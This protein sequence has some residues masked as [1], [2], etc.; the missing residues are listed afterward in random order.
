[1]DRSPEYHVSV[2]QALQRCRGQSHELHWSKRWIGLTG[3]WT[4]VETLLKILSKP[5]SYFHAC[6]DTYAGGTSTAAQGAAS[7]AMLVA[8]S[9]TVMLVAPSSTAVMLVAPSSAVVMLVAPSSTA[10][11][12]VAL[13]RHHLQRRRRM[14]AQGAAPMLVASLAAVIPGSAFQPSAS[15]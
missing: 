5:A 10:V 14:L 9:T 6:P 4:R 7:A 3:C 12:L 11:V 1:M 8:S 2:Y 15:P 13:R